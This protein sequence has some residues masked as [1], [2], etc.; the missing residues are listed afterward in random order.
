VLEV[1][2]LKGVHDFVW[3]DGEQ[4]ARLLGDAVLRLVE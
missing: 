4:L 1:R 2:D 3:R